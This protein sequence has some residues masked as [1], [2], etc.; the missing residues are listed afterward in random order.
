MPYGTTSPGITTRRY[1]SGSIV[2]FEGDK[3]EFVYILKSGKVT[4]TY[5]KLESGEEVKEDVKPG[6]FFGVKSALGKY[7]REETAQIIGETSVLVLKQADF[8][9]YVLGNVAVVKKMLRVFSNQLRRIG[10][11]VREVLGETNLVDP[12]NELFK[13]GEYYSRNGKYQQALYAY[14]RYMEYYPDGRYAQNAMNKIKNIENGDYA[15]ATIPEKVSVTEPAAAEPDFGDMPGF[16]DDLQG[17]AGGDDFGEPDF[18][19]GFDSESDTDS[20]FGDDMGDFGGEPDFAEDSFSFESS[21]TETTELGAEMNSFLSMGDDTADAVPGGIGGAG[22][23][24][25]LDDFGSGLDDDLGLDM[26]DESG[27]FPAEGILEK[28]NEA[29]SMMEEGSYTEA[30]SAFE[31][32]SQDESGRV[33]DESLYLKSHVLTGKC[34]RCAGDYK[35]ALTVLSQFI[36]ANPAAG[37]IRQALLEVGL[38][39]QEAGQGEKGAG[40]LKKVTAMTPRD[41]ITQQALSALRKM[42]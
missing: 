40:Y 13:I 5:L 24:M 21:S 36:K 19:G 34:Y 7:P 2:Y 32:I 30:A 14:K 28:Y 12:A 22:D 9:R 39:Y 37:E 42:M 10:K 3:S 38:T 29:V 18:G 15:A 11:A 20:G 16:G 17:D 4:L 41:D 27:G 23:E 1:K 31:A 33:Q 8:E 25:D 35:R 26:E 6:E